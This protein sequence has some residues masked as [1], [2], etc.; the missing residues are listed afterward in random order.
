MTEDR[1]TIPV[2]DTTRQRA[3]EAGA[4]VR[5]ED[6]FNDPDD[7]RWD[8]VDPAERRDWIDVMD[9]GLAAAVP[10]VLDDIEAYIVEFSARDER[11]IETQR[12]IDDALAAIRR[13][14]DR[15]GWSRD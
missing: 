10:V 2:A 14:R 6:M 7:D 4:R 15:N 9:I 11:I 5:Y 3:A 8:E 12:G 13:L 1:E